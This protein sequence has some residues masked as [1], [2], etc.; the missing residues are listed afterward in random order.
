MQRQ[1]LTNAVSRQPQQHP[2]TQRASTW[3]ALSNTPLKGRA[4]AARHGVTP[5]TIAPTTSCVSP[6]SICRSTPHSLTVHAA[7]RVWVLDGTSFESQKKRRSKTAFER[8]AHSWSESATRTHVRTRKR[9]ARVRDGSTKQESF[10]IFLE[11][12][13]HH[14][15]TRVLAHSVVDRDIDLPDDGALVVFQSTS[16]H[17]FLNP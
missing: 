5:S 2:D 12:D 9:W 1:R 3:L 14:H 13:C 10:T 8:V 6:A 16:T 4:F 15:Q 7:H 11:F 17:A